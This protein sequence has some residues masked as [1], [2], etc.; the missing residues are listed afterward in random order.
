MRLFRHMT[1]LLLLAGPAGAQTAAGDFPLAAE[2]GPYRDVIVAPDAFA[3]EGGAMRLLFPAVAVERLSGDRVFLRPGGDRRV[4]VQTSSAGR[5][6]FATGAEL[7]F[8]DGP[9]LVGRRDGRVTM[10]A[11]LRSIALPLIDGPDTARG[12]IAF[13]EEGMDFTVSWPTRPARALQAVDVVLSAAGMQ[14]DGRL[15]SP[16]GAA[17]VPALR[18]GAIDLLG[19]VAMRLTDEPAGLPD[20]VASIER[21]EIDRSRAA[22]LGGGI[23]ASG[24]AHVS[25]GA[26]A[27]LTDLV[28]TLAL[29]DF[30]TMIGQLMTTRMI[31]PEHLMPLAMLAGGLGTLTPDGTLTF[32]IVT[33]E[34][35]EVVVNDRPTAF[36]LGR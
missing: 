18:V 29:G 31:A 24:V 13:A 1:I 25:P 21:V 9:I 32:D 23:A 28:G 34:G 16:P 30:S 15:L 2:A 6:G 19:R 20:I 33:T 11:R 3:G 26:G 4:I 12:K 17:S 5:D 14:V 10:K 8:T 22:L 7:Y 36:R 27:P 35:G